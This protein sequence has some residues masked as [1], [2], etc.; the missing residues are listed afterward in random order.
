MNP[1]ST[2]QGQVVGF[3]D[4]SRIWNGHSHNSSFHCCPAKF[5]STVAQY[6]CS[7]LGVNLSELIY[8]HCSVTLRM[9]TP[10]TVFAGTSNL[11][12]AIEGLEKHMNDKMTSIK[13]ELT[14][15]REQADERLVKRMKIEKTPT[16]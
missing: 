5:N 2:G 8:W 13:R 6:Y 3:K 12:A 9:A 7:T 15:E 14:Q 16:T 1:V 10:P 4:D 11:L